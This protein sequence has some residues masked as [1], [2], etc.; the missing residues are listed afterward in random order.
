MRGMVTMLRRDVA[1]AF[2]RSRP[3]A[4]PRSISTTCILSR[5]SPAH[6]AYRMHL[7]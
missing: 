4:Y 5:I 2:S 1:Y 3:M 6:V 7:R